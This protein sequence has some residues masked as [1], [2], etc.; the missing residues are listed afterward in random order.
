MRP[1]TLAAARHPKA[2]TPCERREPRP[3]WRWLSGWK[4]FPSSRPGNSTPSPAPI[5]QLR[6]CYEEILVALHSDL[7]VF[8]TDLIWRSPSLYILVRGPDFCTGKRRAGE[9]GHMETH[10]RSRA[11]RS[12]RFP[13]R[14]R[15]WRNRSIPSQRLF[16][17]L[18]LRGRS[19]TLRLR[20]F[21]F[22]DRINLQPDQS[23]R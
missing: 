1:A 22:G 15:V 8:A 14:D 3:V 11:V 13:S 6:A 19:G 4:Q 10:D 12:S 9:L 2:R 18:V 16:G 20:I 21:R 5:L 7:G 17:G 23:S